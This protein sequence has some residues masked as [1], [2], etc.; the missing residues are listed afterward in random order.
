M[1]KKEIRYNFRIDCLNRDNDT[2]KMCGH[3][4]ATR[5]EALEIFD[6]HHI[7]FYM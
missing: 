7:I 2:C 3:K 5:Q 1:S 4:A 6:V